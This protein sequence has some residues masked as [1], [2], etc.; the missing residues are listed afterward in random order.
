MNKNFKQLYKSLLENKLNSKL[1]INEAA[2]GG[3]KWWPT[4]RN[5]IGRNFMNRFPTM[6]GFLEYMSRSSMHGMNTGASLRIRAGGGTGFGKTSAAVR[7]L[8]ELNQHWN[9]P[10]K[11]LEV[12]I[13]SEGAHIAITDTGEYYYMH[14]VNG[15]IKLP[16]GFNPFTDHIPDEFGHISWF[17]EGYHSPINGTAL[18]A[19]LLGGEFADQI[20]NQNQEWHPPLLPPD[21]D[22]TPQYGSGYVPPYVSRPVEDEYM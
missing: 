22:A 20:L 17:D 1:N 6:N 21:S 5:L 10:G 16:D 11:I 4:I 15:Y 7:F 14:P 8:E 13:N 19:L 18:G 12:L 2:G 9:K 3:P